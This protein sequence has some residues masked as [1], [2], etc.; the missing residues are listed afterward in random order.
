MRFRLFLVLLIG[1]FVASPLRAQDPAAAAA[2]AVV[3]AASL[4]QPPQPIAGSCQPPSYPTLL[5][6]SQIE[7]RVILEFVV[8]T[9]GRIEPSSVNTISS[10]HSQFERAARQALMSCRYRPASFNQQLARVLVR[11]PYTFALARN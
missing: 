4:E 8:D 10:S 3:N 6:A 5:R 1:L 2:A 7:G 9:T 11:M